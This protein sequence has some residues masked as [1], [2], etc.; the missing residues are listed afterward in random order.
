MAIKLMF[1]TNDPE[2]ARKAEKSGADRIFIDLEINGKLERQGHLDTVISRHSMSDVPKVKAVLEKSELLVRVN[3]LFEGSK[4][5][6]DEAVEHGADVVMLP[7]FK[8]VEEVEQFV[9]YVNKRA[10][11][12]LLMET[13]QAM[14]RIHDIVNVKG[15][16]EIHIGLND[17]HLGLGLDFMFELLDSG[18]VEYLSDVIKS[19][20]ITFGFGGIARVGEGLLP[21]EKIIR[22]HVRL[23]SEIAILSRTFHKRAD[24]IEELNDSLDFREEIQ[25]IRAIERDAQNFTKEQFDENRMEI[26][27]CVDHIAKLM[28]ENKK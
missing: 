21:A 15:I 3:P 23:G 24:S 22:E 11:I 7:M 20:E 16:D 4:R 9:E 10:K 28:R 12:C 1:I 13:P 2:M 17:L 14:V 8:T 19:K 27:K 6:I 26:K 5:E 18:I 25:K